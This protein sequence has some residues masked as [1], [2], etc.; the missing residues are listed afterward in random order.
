MAQGK[1]RRPF[2]Y[3]VLAS[4]H[5]YLVSIGY[6]MPY[7]CARAVCA[8]FC[9]SIAPALIPIFGLDFPEICTIPGSEGYGNMKIE[10]TIVKAATREAEMFRQRY[11]R[12]Q[13]SGSTQA[14][15]V[16]GSSPS[17]HELSMRQDTITVRPAQ[18]ARQHGHEV[19]PARDFKLA[20]TPLPTYSARSYYPSPETPL[21]RS[22]EFSWRASPSRGVHR[23]TSA[24]RGCCVAISPRSHAPLVDDEPDRFHGR[25]RQQLPSGARGRSLASSTSRKRS[26]DSVSPG[27]HETRRVSQRGRQ[28]SSP[29]VQHYFSPPNSSYPSST[30]SEA[31]MVPGSLQSSPCT[32]QAR[33]HEI[34]SP[35]VSKMSAQTEY[36]SEVTS[37]SAAKALLDLGGLDD[38]H[39]HVRPQKRARTDREPRKGSDEI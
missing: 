14:R 9:H 33:M 25:T 23:S 5:A 18:H 22:P 26:I 34:D 38:K 17:H 28:A 12:T 31:P 8:T 2:H 15:L 1:L 7:T 16:C 3:L 19:V 10:A 11:G 32:V 30:C 6:W 37:R 20:R 39:W 21:L 35:S 29:E 36:Q 27:S 13:D 24:G 4:H